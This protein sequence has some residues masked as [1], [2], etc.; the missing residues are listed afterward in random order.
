MK[1]FDFKFFIGV[2]AC[3]LLSFSGQAQLLKG[4]VKSKHLQDGATLIFNGSKNGVA[5]RYIKLTFDTGGNF[6]F[7]DKDMAKQ[8]TEATIYLGDYSRWGIF[9]QKG[10]T[11]VF[12]AIENTQKEAVGT[13]DGDNIAMSKFSN[14]FVNNFELEHYV[15]FED[16]DVRPYSQCVARLAGC[17]KEVQAALFKIK[18]PEMRAYY[19][20]Y[21]KMKNLFLQLRMLGDTLYKA[22]VDN[23]TNTQYQV[24]IGQIDVND[25]FGLRCSLPQ[26]FIYNKIPEALKGSYGNDMTNFALA[27]IEMIKKYVTNTEVKDVLAEDLAHD[28]FSYGKGND[29]DKFWPVFKDFAG[30]N[31]EL[32]A[33]YQNKVD[34]TKNT[35]SGKKSPDTTFSDVNGKQHKLSD[36]FGK[37]IYIDIWATWCGPCCKEIPHLE[38]LVEHYKGNDKIQ[39]ISISVDSNRE[40]WLNK[41]KKDKPSWLQFN[42][43]REEDRAF[44]KAWNINGIPRFIIIDKNG[45]I[46]DADAIRPSDKEIVS[47]LDKLIR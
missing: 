30:S 26:F 32:V 29:I 20:K 22:K 2:T 25:P 21:A 15:A 37:L 40:A 27:N 47:T 41:L 1:H 19:T 9:L 12:T 28:Y 6:A 7:D 45:N 36:Y 46:C 43:N 42:L 13:Y 5:S 33:R 14:L 39:F 11:A 17:Y 44:A 18:D 8:Y 31:S 38:K 34:A 4:N 16:T 3:L 23:G 10:K 24:L 35:A